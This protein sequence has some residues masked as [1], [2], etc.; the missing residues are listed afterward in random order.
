MKKLL[1]TGANGFVGRHVLAYLADDY[2]DTEVWAAVRHIDPQLQK[3]YPHVH[4]V[5]VDMLDDAALTHVIK[6]SQPDSILHLAAASSVGYSWQEPRHSTLNN[7]NIYL[8]LLEAVRHEAP[9]ARLLS[10]G[11]SEVYGQVDAASLPLC[12]EDPVQPASPYA[13]ARASQEFLS[14]VYEDGYGLDIVMTRSFNHIGPGQDGRFAIPSFARQIA[15]AKRA[16]QDRCTLQ[17]GNVDVVRDFT[18]VRDVVTAYM[19]LLAHGKRGEIY[20][21][22]SGQGRSLRD[23]IGLLASQAGVNVTLTTDPKLVRPQDLPVIYGDNARLKADTGWTAQV[24]F[25][26]TVQTVMNEWLNAKDPV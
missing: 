9:K 12:E 4:W 23:V 10:V 11:S 6:T 18:D 20:N 15:T 19:S 17:V 7:L 8:N 3:K 14:K 24:E 13:V 22:C 1:L 2:A 5:E 21:I 26:K 16:G 25:S